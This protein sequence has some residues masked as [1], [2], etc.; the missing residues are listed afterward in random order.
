MRL[1]SVES[2]GALEVEILGV[3]S[4]CRE[5][6][7]CLLVSKITSPIQRCGHRQKTTIFNVYLYVDTF[8]P[9]HTNVF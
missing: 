5:L 1:R 2:V 4:V 8:V 9:Q 3:R 7:A 6:T